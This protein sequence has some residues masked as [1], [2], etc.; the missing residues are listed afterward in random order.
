MG[1]KQFTYTKKG[2]IKGLNIEVTPTTI[3]SDHQPFFVL[4]SLYGSTDCSITE[5]VWKDRFM[6]VNNLIQLGANIT[7]KDNTIFIKPSN[8]NYYTGELPSLDVRSGA[9]TL[10]SIIATKSACTLTDSL[11][12]FRG[13][14]RLKEQMQLMGIDLEYTIST[15]I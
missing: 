15:D 9:V 3:Q 14:S 10:L 13:Y 2:D 8:L 7:I 4:L 6:Y 1:K 11:H 12:I 5:Y